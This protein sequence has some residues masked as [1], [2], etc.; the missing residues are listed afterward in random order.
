MASSV[1]KRQQ[2]RNERALQELIR[3]VPG[4]DRCADCSAKNPG[5]ASWSLGI[6]LCMRC[7]ALHRRLG[8]HVSKVK[9]LSMDSWSTE[10]VDQMKATGNVIS[11]KKYNPDNVRPDIPADADEVEAA[12]WKH[13]RQKY[14]LRA[15]SGGQPRKAQAQ[16]SRQNTGSTGT[17]G[18]HT[19]EPA[20][21]PPKP[22][23]RFG[24]SLRSSSST[25]SRSKQQDRFT[26]PRSPTLGATV[27]DR[28]GNDLVSPV[29]TNKPS[30]MFGMRITTIDNNFN[31]K[32]IHLRD[33]GFS[34]PVKNTDI[35]KSM[36]GNLD[37]AIETLI[38]LGEGDAKGL[39]K[40]LP[41]TSTPASGLLT[42]LSASAGGLN[43]DK[44]R[45]PPT[46]QKSTSNPWEVRETTPA[47]SV[48]QPVAG[49]EPPRAQS[50]PPTNAWNPFLSAS[51][52]ASPVSPP[53]ASLTDS[54]HSLQVSQTGPSNPWMAQSQ[55]Q[56]APQPQQDLLAAAS[57]AYSG[58]QWPA[59]TGYTSPQPLQNNPFFQQQ[60]Q[61]MQQAQ[62]APQ[63]AQIQSQQYAQSPFATQSPPPASNPWAQQLSPQ[64]TQQMY[65]QQSSPAQQ[66]AASN[67]FGSQWQQPQS[68]T[69][70][71]IFQQ[72]P[73]ASPSPIYGT[74]TDFFSAPQPAQQQPQQLQQ[75]QAQAQFQQQQQQQ[76]Q[77]QQFQQ[78]QPQQPFQPQSQ[79]YATTPASPFRHDK[80]S[81]LALYGNLSP[82]QSLPEN[83]VAQ[84]Q[85][86]QVPQRSATMP[87]SSATVAPGAGSMNP[88]QSAPPP[89]AANA[90]PRHV[91]NVSLDFQ[92]LNGAGA[93]G[94]GATGAA[95]GRLSPDAFSGLSARFGVR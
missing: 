40:P 54:F 77:F 20:A 28:D 70:Q 1:T 94:F 30:Q 85:Q 89:V 42:P 76:Q 66:Q 29:S 39:N 69:V 3:T 74:Q 46:P 52:A 90:A 15:L 95:S 16:A 37:K 50:V 5:W 6:F 38:R 78:Q 35:L 43:V 4:N 92:G 47:R 34:D 7:A 87:A 56:Q 48:S 82:L 27:S 33:M 72:Q 17:G 68:Q 81:I 32:L 8:T 53:V 21:L 51:S 80:N 59:T 12:L 58:Q 10:Q 84:H 91:S 26:P 44:Q 22:G 25:V 65:Q 79:P 9:S 36:G 18:S 67:P 31:A 75:Q 73:T 2:A 83:G 23:K 11:N 86:Q 13:I 57:V 24:F 49:A 60:P 93:A 45:A 61:Q 63:Q 14:E 64:P 71:S 41:R 88:F 55:M 19:E 62:F